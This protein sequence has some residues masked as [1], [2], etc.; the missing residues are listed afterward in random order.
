MQ[1]YCNIMQQ[2]RLVVDVSIILLPCLFVGHRNMAKVARRCANFRI[3]SANSAVCVCG[4][5]TGSL[6]DSAGTALHRDPQLVAMAMPSC[7]MRCS[8]PMNAV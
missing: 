5:V 8:V 2:C 3:W 4:C 7:C 6:L 1:W